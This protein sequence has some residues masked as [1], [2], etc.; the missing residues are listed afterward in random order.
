[1]LKHNT[2]F[3]GAVQSLGFERNGLKATVGVIDLG[4]FRF[5][6]AGAERMTVVSG[7]LSAKLPSGDWQLYPAGS[8]FEVPAASAF[9]IRAEGGP[10]AYLCEFISR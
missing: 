6:T 1:M 10:A 5:S 4:E 2:Y 8:Y 7:A 9:D 3:D